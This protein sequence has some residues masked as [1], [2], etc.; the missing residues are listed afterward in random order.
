[1]AAIDVP[2]NGP[3]KPRVPESAV[4]ERIGSISEEQWTA[5][6]A[7]LHTSTLRLPDVAVDVVDLPARG[8]ESGP[9]IVLL[10]GFAETPHSFT[11]NLHGLN[12]ARRVLA[13][14]NCHGIDTAP[15][16]GHAHPQLRK[17]QAVIAMLDAK[18]VRGADLVAHSEGGVVASIVARLRPDLIRNIVLLNPAGLMAEE[19]LPALLMRFTLDGIRNAWKGISGVRDDTHRRIDALGG[20]EV[21]RSIREAPLQTASEVLALGSASIAKPLKEAGEAGIGVA[22]ITA[23]EDMLFPLHRR[24]RR[25]TRETGIPAEHIHV[26]PGGHVA[27]T[28]N[29]VIVTRTVQ[30]A[31]QGLERSRATRETDQAST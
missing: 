15:I 8:P 22:L 3:E 19:S 31:L 4:E 30:E 28:E 14:G 25:I 17:A 24:P 20:A 26:I 21:G 6:Q 1:M 9:A 2:D 7:L 16:R 12:D 23:K 13:V 27:H 10:P 18:G 11:A 29:H 5:M